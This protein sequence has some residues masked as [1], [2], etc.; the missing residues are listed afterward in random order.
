MFQRLSIL[1]IACVALISCSDDDSLVPTT[2]PPV[3][4]DIRVSKNVDEIVFTDQA[5]LDS[6]LA[7]AFTFFYSQTPSVHTTTNVVVDPTSNTATASIMFA[8]GLE[9][10]YQ[11]LAPDNNVAMISLVDQS[12]LAPFDLVITDVTATDQGFGV[13]DIAVEINNDGDLELNDDITVTYIVDGAQVGANTIAGPLAAGATTMDNFNGYQ[14]ATS[15][16]YQLTVRVQTAAMEIDT[17]NNEN[18]QTLNVTF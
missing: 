18:V 7:S 16:M 14:F 17:T 2:P 9:T 5:D 4:S 1:A 13:Y 11:D 12:T 15:G 8:P 3:V 10:Y 6:Q